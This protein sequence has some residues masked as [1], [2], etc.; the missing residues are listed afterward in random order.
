MGELSRKFDQGSEKVLK[1]LKK[2]Q[3]F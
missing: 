1:V 3:K 2:F